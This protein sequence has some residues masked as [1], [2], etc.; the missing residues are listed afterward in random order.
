[1]LSSSKLN[2]YSI[3]PSI[4]ILILLTACANPVMDGTQIQTNMS[5]PGSLQINL[6]ISETD[7]SVVPEDYADAI[8]SYE[9]LLSGTQSM[10]PLQVTD[11]V[12]L[13]EDLPL[14]DYTV[15]VVAL[16]SEGVTLAAGSVSEVSVTG[17]E[18]G[19]VDIEL[20]PVMGGEG[21]I[22]VN[23]D[24][25]AA[26][27]PAGGVDKVIATLTPNGGRP[28][29][30]EVEI[31]DNGLRF[32]GEYPTGE[33]VFSCELF[34]DGVLI[35]SVAETVQVFDGFETVTDIAFGPELFNTVP[36]APGTPETNQSGLSVNLTWIDTSDLET[37]YT[38][39]RSDDGGEF[40]LVGTGLPAN[41]VSWTDS[42]QVP[43]TV[44][45]YRIIAVNAFGESEA[46]EISIKVD[47]LIRGPAEP[48]SRVSNLILGDSENIMPLTLLLEGFDNMLNQ[49]GL[50]ILSV[51]IEGGASVRIEHC[52]VIIDASSLPYELEGEEIVLGYTVHIIG[53][54]LNDTYS[55]DGMLRLLLTAPEVEEIAEDDLLEPIQGFVY[56]K[57][58]AMERKMFLYEPPDPQE[59]FDNWGRLSNHAYFSNGEDAETSKIKR[60]DEADMALLWKLKKDEEGS[61]IEYARNSVYAG[62][63][64]P[65]G[66]ESEKYTL[67][68]TVTS[69]DDDD[70]TVGIIV[71]FL[72]DGNSNYVLEAARSQGSSSGEDNVEPRQGWGLIVR[73]L[74]PEVDKPEIG[75]VLWSRQLNIGGVKS[76][77]WKNTRSRIK[78]VRNGD[79]VTIS[80]TDWDDEGNYVPGSVIDVNL[81]SEHQL[82]RFTGP[83]KF[84]YF[85]ASQERTSF[86]DISMNGG[87]IQD[88]LFYLDPE[89]GESEVWWYDTYSK[90]WIRMMGTDIQ[91]V[92]GYP[93]EITNPDTGE[94]YLIERRGYR[95]G[96][97]Q[98]WRNRWDEWN[99]Q[100]RR[101][102]DDKV[103]QSS[104]IIIDREQ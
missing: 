34:D 86:R 81:G 29:F 9:I 7:R 82:A 13:L 78:V 60:G 36:E 83:R 6:M 10:G 8:E 38:I 44:Y 31:F 51:T 91:E 90:R 52:I 56:D 63:V 41:T 55:T 19:I 71:A 20:L 17:D 74:S 12:V 4:L 54:P 49:S 92:L 102:E 67:E 101:D 68:A 40:S 57:H 93:L 18:M 73:R 64:S 23:Y 96:R 100:D 75:D 32:T 85:T 50:E 84:G 30:V 97:W 95:R 39:Y 48:E 99:R 1:M 69:K 22:L 42:P 77:G 37:G 89:T 11:S 72:R 70:D 46:H 61:Y 45:T 43:G 2:G 58:C 35:S 59:I 21:S 87:V 104:L 79:R 88:K 28:I 94:T 103:H 65:D 80:T 26:G 53:E 47:P 15:S 33:Y 76:D 24:W 66:Q 5:S 25:S 98:D 14:G 16:D 3:L 62:L 27:F